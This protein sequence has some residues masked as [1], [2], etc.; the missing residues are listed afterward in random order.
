MRNDEK[1]DINLTQETTGDLTEEEKVQQNY[2]TALRY[3]NIAKHMKKFEDQDKYY[4][5][6]IK[7]LKLV[8]PHRNVR[9]L[10]RELRTKK[11]TARAQGKIELYKEACEIR[12]KAKTPNDYYSAQT[13][14]FRIHQ[15]EQNHPIIEK[16]VT[17]EVYAEAS[18]CSDSE[19]QARLCQELAREKSAQLKRHNLL[20]SSIVILL[21]VAALFFTRTISFRQCLASSYSTFKD[22][23]SAWQA[24]EYIYQKNGN[25]DAHMKALFFRYKSAQT[26][27]SKG[28]ENTAY[29]NYKALAKENYKDSHQK[30]VELEKEH[31]KHT[32]IGEKV[33]FGY[34][35]WRVL[36]KEEGKILLL[37]DNSIG[38][39]PFNEDGG[40]TTWESS[41][42]RRWLNSSFLE[43]SFFKEEQDIILTTEVKNSPNPV[44]NTP[45][46]P[47]TSD[48]L[49]LL[50]YDEAL[51][52]QKGIHRTK[53]CWWLRTPGNEK[54]SV[55]FMYR[56]KTVM[57]YG[58]DSDNTN[59]TVKPA[60][61]VNVE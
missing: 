15:Y 39:T 40:N 53:S 25:K 14:F 52:Y 58:Y 50:S 21:V 49:F 27:A 59:I 8:Q 7:Y 46:G 11:F 55:C 16:W 29:V 41:S 2:E 43:D 47:D 51:H 6:A 19:E 1:I 12:D 45:A 30:F 37:K 17:P 28:D 42:V 35:D 24:Y 54:N 56:N 18:R 23:E 5:R 13:I 57:D 44:Y 32:K 33:S 34:M 3:I 22:Y 61:W 38:S 36:A 20:V 60:M 48:K 4:H 10:I 31:I 9:P 26:A